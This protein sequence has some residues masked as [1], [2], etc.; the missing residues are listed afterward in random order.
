MKYD[1]LNLQYILPRQ[2][3]QIPFDY[4]NRRNRKKLL[5]SHT[6]L[7]SDIKSS[8][9]FISNVKEDALDLFYIAEK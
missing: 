7:T 3:L 2:I 1:I 5:T 6:N 9:F 4:L 8:D